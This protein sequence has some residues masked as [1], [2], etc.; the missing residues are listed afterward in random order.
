MSYTRWNCFKAKHQVMSNPVYAHI[1]HTFRNQ[2]N[3]RTTVVEANDEDEGSQGV[4]ESDTVSEED[5]GHDQESGEEQLDAPSWE[6]SAIVEA[7][8]TKSTPSKR[9]RVTNSPS[10]SHR[11]SV[12]KASTIGPI[13][14][15]DYSHLLLKKFWEPVMKA[16][17]KIKALQK[18]AKVQRE[19]MRKA[20]AVVDEYFAV[21]DSD[22][23]EE[24]SQDEQ[25]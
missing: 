8:Q 18:Q 23:E 19:V 2:Y 21:K 24:E 22:V 11:K 14:E 7:S 17:R 10:R 25:E 4:E 9:S 1:Y 3:S 5:H 20:L 6:E 12:S 13:D 16:K 15:Y